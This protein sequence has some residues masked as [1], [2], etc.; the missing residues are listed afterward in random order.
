MTRAFLRDAR[1][2]R[3]L[4]GSLAV[5]LAGAWFYAH[6]SHV[7]SGTGHRASHG[8]TTLAVDP[9]AAKRT[10]GRIARAA[11]VWTSPRRV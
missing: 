3:P 7:P 11:I 8:S 5:V 10:V 2:A 1:R 6:N 9:L 4:V